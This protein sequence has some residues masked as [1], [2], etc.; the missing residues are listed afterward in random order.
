MKTLN[1]MPVAFH[2]LTSITYI[3]VY[4]FNILVSIHFYYSVMDFHILIPPWELFLS[5]SYTVRITI[6]LL[7][8]KPRNIFMEEI[9]DAILGTMFL[10]PFREVHVSGSCAKPLF[11]FL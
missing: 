7:S 9:L 1:H 8:S 4:A 5:G 6:N 10:F 2:T 3:P 11:R